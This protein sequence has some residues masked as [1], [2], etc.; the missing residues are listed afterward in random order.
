MLWVSFIFLWCLFVIYEEDL[1]IVVKAISLPLVFIASIGLIFHSRLHCH[2]SAKKKN[3]TGQ[4]IKWRSEVEQ[5]GKLLFM[6][7]LKS[8]GFAY[9]LLNYNLVKCVAEIKSLS[10]FQPVPFHHNVWEFPLRILR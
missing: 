10:K 6:E 4:P 9:L 2:W 3:K 8:S 7:L 1:K 5:I